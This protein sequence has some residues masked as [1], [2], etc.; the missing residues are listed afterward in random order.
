MQRMNPLNDFEKYYKK[1]ETL[2]IENVKK[3]PCYKIKLTPKVGKPETVFIDT[4]E[5]MPLRTKSKVPSAMGEMAMSEF[6]GS[7]AFILEP[8]AGGR[9]RLT[10]RLRLWVSD[11]GAPQRL[12]MPMMGLGVFVMTRKHMLGLKERAEQATAEG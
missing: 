11:S 10:E 5:Y 8:A 12:V 2:A 4:K 1:W 7:W 6:R 9:T 3:V